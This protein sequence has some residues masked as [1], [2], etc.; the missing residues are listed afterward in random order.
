M[1]LNKAKW[2]SFFIILILGAFSAG[3]GV[4]ADHDDH[5]EKGEHSNSYE[6][7]YQGN[8]NYGDDGGY[9][10]DDDDEGEEENWGGTGGD[11]QQT[12][13]QTGYWNFWMREAV[14]TQDTQLPI[15][16]PT[17]VKV[18]INGVANSIHVIPQSGQL[19]VPGE[20]LAK[21]ISAKTNYYPKSKIFTIKNT[22]TEL[23]VR[24]GSN[25]AYENQNKTPM[26][27]QAQYIEKSLY[28]PISVVGN[29]M[30]YRVSW[31]EAD[32]SLVL[33]NI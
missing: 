27:I 5:D 1:K 14:S 23:I 6:E 30:G 29:A 17:E 28:I 19:L 11:F 8:D 21:L 13:S 16:T 20:K 10:D 7:Q 15:S 24:A 32:Q 33:E 22:D 25:A 31:N 3:V 18:T 2:F 26:P 4:L 12:P 9:D